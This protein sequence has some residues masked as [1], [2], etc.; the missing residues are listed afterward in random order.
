MVA[1]VFLHVTVAAVHIVRRLSIRHDFGPSTWDFFWYG[2]TTAGLRE[3]PSLWHLH[4]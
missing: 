3:I 4:A 1:V 2:L